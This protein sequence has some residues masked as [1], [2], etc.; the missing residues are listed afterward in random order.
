MRAP[1]LS[2]VLSNAVP[3]NYSFV[4]LAPLPLS[5]PPSSSL[6]ALTGICL[7]GCTPPSE[8]SST[9]HAH[10][11]LCHRRGQWAATTAPHLE[12][13]VHLAAGALRDQRPGYPH[14]T[15]MGY[16]ATNV[17]VLI[18][19]TARTAVSILGFSSVLSSSVYDRRFDPGSSS[20]TT[21]C[22]SRCDRSALRAR[23]GWQTCV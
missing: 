8:S 7:R 1:F 3:N 2:H 17:N 15:V 10:P 14:D 20:H 4:Y 11:H 6:S 18:I 12:L 22:A 23:P 21:A 5:R 19:A 13:R 9:Y 16:G